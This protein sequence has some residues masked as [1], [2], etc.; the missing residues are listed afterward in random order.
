MNEKNGMLQSFVEVMR[1]IE[2]DLNIVDDAYLI[3]T[4]CF[5]DPIQNKPMFYRV[6]EI[7]EQ[8]YFQ[9]LADKGVYEAVANI[10]VWL[11]EPLEQATKINAQLQECQ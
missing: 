8:I 3:L 6:K 7:T 1:E 4:K 11:I 2:M 9:I 5:V 10:Q